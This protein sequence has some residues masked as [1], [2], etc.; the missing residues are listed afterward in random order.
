MQPTT[1]LTLHPFEGDRRALLVKLTAR[2]RR[3]FA[4]MAERHEGWVDEILSVYDTAEIEHL[5]A[6][7]DKV[8]SEEHN[9]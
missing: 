8:A 1:S 5:A 2:G 6:L 7:L 4:A 3:Q 9:P